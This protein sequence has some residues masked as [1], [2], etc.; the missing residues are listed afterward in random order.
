MKYTPSKD[1]FRNIHNEAMDLVTFARLGI[2]PHD[3]SRVRTEEDK[4]R[5]IEKAF[6]LEKQAI[7]LA[8][9]RY[10]QT[11]RDGDKLT[12]TIY[13][14]SGAWMA[15]KAG[16]FAEAEN[17]AL[18]ALARG[19]HPEDKA[20]LL[21]AYFTALKKQGY[22]LRTFEEKEDEFEELEDEEE[23]VNTPIPGF[24]TSSMPIAELVPH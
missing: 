13:S 24:V 11:Q 2:D 3:R 6:E 5:D 22:R 12:E 9:A 18:T 19:A 7:A 17:I 16:W 23:N 10:D 21:E 14:R 15:I 1:N 4:Q 8:Q 20:K